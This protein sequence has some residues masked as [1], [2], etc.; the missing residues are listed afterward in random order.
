MTSSAG[1]DAVARGGPPVIIHRHARI[2]PRTL[3]RGLLLLVLGAVGCRESLTD[4]T[5]GRRNR[6]P[7]AVAP[8]PSLTLIEGQVVLVEVSPYFTDPN[9]DAL[10]YEATTD[11]ATARA[12]VSGTLVAVTAVSPGTS[13][14]ILTARDPGGLAATQSTAVTVRRNRAPLAKGSIPVVSLASGEILTLEVAPYFNDP[15]GGA[16]GYQAASSNPRVA[17]A[18]V[19]GAT[20]SVSAVAAG[21][22]TLTL[23]ATDPGG[24]TASHAVAVTVVPGPTLGFRE[25]FDSSLEEWE[26]A[27]GAT[28]VSDGVLALTNVAAGIAGRVNRRLEAPINFW[29]ARARLGRTQTDSVIASV[30]FSTGHERYAAYALDVGSG[31]SVEGNDTNYRFYVLDRT[32]RWPAENPWIVIEGAF[33]VSDAVHDGAGEFTEINATLDDANLRVRASDTELFAVTLDAEHP[34][35]LTSIGLWVFPL[36]G[37]EARTALFDWVEVSG[38]QTTAAATASAAMA[39]SARMPRLRR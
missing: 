27:E 32:R 12:T 1:T 14:L 2:A 34:T 20:M 4:Y 15:D 28:V 5:L 13:R 16:L 8:I 38:T 24:L 9:G 21:T 29:E 37:A 6:A 33:G 19:T 11:A 30:I 17:L 7:V 36:D 22:A 25:D 39:A 3:L 35:R 23:T 26:V 31:V 18:S 10:A